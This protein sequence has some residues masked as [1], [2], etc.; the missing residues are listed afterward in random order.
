MTPMMHWLFTM[1]SGAY[2]ELYHRIAGADGKAVNPDH[3]RQ[4]MEKWS[5]TGRRDQLVREATAP[6]M[7]RIPFHPNCRGTVVAKQ[8]YVYMTEE[9][10]R[11]AQEY[12]RR[13]F[14]LRFE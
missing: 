5:Q 9:Q 7:D 13:F 3:A 14:G 12:L 6:V 1:M 10:K 2:P 11:Q 4:V 8:T